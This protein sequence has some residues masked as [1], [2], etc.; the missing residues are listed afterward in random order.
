MFPLN[1]KLDWVLSTSDARHIGAVN[2]SYELPVGEGKR[3]FGN[4]H[5]FA[6]K[7]ASGWTLSGI[8]TL[9]TGFPFTPQ[10]GFNPSNNGDSRNPVRPEQTY[11]P[12]N[13]REP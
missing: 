8:E 10:L 6:Q 2:A 7:L 12:P 9:Q 5:G 13:S 3:F 1:P 11:S 4:V